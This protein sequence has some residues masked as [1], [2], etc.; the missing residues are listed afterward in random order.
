M[1]RFLVAK[2]VSLWLFMVA[3]ALA[4]T[5]V[6][7]AL[8]SAYLGTVGVPDP[9]RQTGDV[10]TWHLAALSPAASWSSPLH[11]LAALGIAGCVWLLLIAAGTALAAAIRKPLIVLVAWI[12][13]LAAAGL[14]G[15]RSNAFSRTFT[16]PI[17]DVLHLASTPYGVRDTEFWHVANRPS[18]LDVLPGTRH[19]ALD[20]VALWGLIALLVAVIAGVA[21]SRRRVLG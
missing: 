4:L 5:T 15:Q 2:V 1:G 12:A 8:Q 21:A 7:Y 11:G 3:F 6:L 13:C 17:G 9:P 19:L 20:G 18:S 16:R 14:A 10:S